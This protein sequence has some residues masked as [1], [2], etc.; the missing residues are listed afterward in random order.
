MRY[1]GGKAKIA[2]ALAA[3]MLA[4]RGTRPVWEP[5]CGGLGLSHVW[6]TGPLVLSDACRPLIAMY[7]AIAAGRWF[8][9]TRAVLPAERNAAL[10]LPDSHPFKAFAR[11]GCGFAGDWAAGTIRSGLDINTGG[12]GGHAGTLAG[13]AA[14]SLARTFAALPLDVEFVWLDFCKVEPYE[15]PE[16]QRALIYCDPPYEGR[17]TYAAV[18]PFDRA[19][20]VA[21]LREWSALGALVF[22]SEFAL[23]IGRVVWEATRARHIAG[24]GTVVERL[25]RV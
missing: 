15:L 1:L 23:P 3:P 6:R 8:P 14:R 22:V 13:Q 12:R 16:A 9:S 20:F 18:G 2:R 24:R 10:A 5:F 25:Y 11:F 4:A 17:E 19:A 7:D 21:R